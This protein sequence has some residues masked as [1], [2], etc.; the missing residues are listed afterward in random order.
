MKTSPQAYYLGSFRVKVVASI[1]VFLKHIGSHSAISSC[2]SAS[3]NVFLKHIRFSSGL[4]LALA[5]AF[6]CVFLSCTSDPHSLRPLDLTPYNIPMTIL[7]PDSA[8]VQVK[9]YKIM[10][11]ITISKGEDF[12]LQLFEVMSSTGDAAGEK[13][14][15]LETVKAAPFFRE[16]LK[17]ED[18]GFIYSTQPD[19]STVEY[20]FRRVKLLGEKEIIFQT[21]LVGDFTLDQVTTMFNAVK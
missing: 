7:A 11:D 5:S 17:E 12:S 3:I 2:C 18:N 20:D 1:N 21:G 10:R 13:L 9:D 6:A 8:I 16:V 15:Q 19:S 14:R 4:V